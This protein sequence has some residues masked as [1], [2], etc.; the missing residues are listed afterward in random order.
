MLS[1]L[2]RWT[3]YLLGA[4]LLLVI[5][6][7]GGVYLYSEVRMRADYEVSVDTLTVDAD[8]AALARGRHVARTRGCRDCH[9]NDFGG[10]TIIDDPMMG[11]L[12]GSNLTSGQGGI[13]DE[14]AKNDWI[15]AIRHGVGPDGR[16]LIFM[17]SYE[18]ASMGRKDLA[19][20]IAY[21]ERL[22]PVDRP[23]GPLEVGPIGRLLYVSG[24]LPQLLSAEI[25][26]H[27]RPIPTAPPADSTVTYG[28][29]LAHGCTG[30][31]GEDFTGGPIPGAP[32]SWPPATN[33]T[34]HPEDGIGHYG[35]EE[36]IRAVRTGQRPDGQM[37][38]E[39]MPFSQFQELTRTEVVA[40]WNYFQSLPPRPSE[41]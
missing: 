11:T 4:V 37:I 20:L 21:L 41:G 27:G 15:R 2:L 16:P 39:V 7:A 9:G 26:D 8:S 28:E 22:E 35:K 14:Y 5:L 19:E 33:L 6:A 12:A 36:F 25:V 13:G 29:Y 10:A 40:L 18:Y 38:D 30:C 1:S 3:G 23:K 31:H 32:P 17:P 34:L 24:N